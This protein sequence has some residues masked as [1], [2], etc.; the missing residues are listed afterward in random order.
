MKAILSLFS[1]TESSLKLSYSFAL[2]VTSGAVITAFGHGD[3]L[4]VKFY[5]SYED[6]LN[7]FEFLLPLERR[8]YMLSLTFDFLF[9][10]SYSLCFYILIAHLYRS[11]FWCKTLKRFVLYAGIFDFIETF[12]SLLVLLRV[13]SVPKFLP[14]AT[15]LKWL[16]VFIN[17]GLLLYGLVLNRVK[18]KR[19]LSA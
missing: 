8:A 16:F 18:I 19:A 4:D 14:M 10:V 12:S 5:Y 17:L 11:S 6:A 3:T 2:F 1:L 15:S 13:I 9:L 7:V